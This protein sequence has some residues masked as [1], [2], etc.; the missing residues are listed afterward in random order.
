MFLKAETKLTLIDIGTLLVPDSTEDS[1]LY[2]YENVYEWFYLLVKEI[3]ITLNVS[4][5]HGFS[6]NDN[7][8]PGATYFCAH[9]NETQLLFDKNIESIAQWIA[10]VLCTDV[11]IHSGKYYVDVP[12]TECV[13]VVSPSENTNTF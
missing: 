2:D 3:S 12:E 5:E 4:R 6:G 9:D 7:I 1:L 8:V 11:S 13:Q 10:N